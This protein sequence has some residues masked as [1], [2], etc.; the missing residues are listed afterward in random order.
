MPYELVGN[1]ETQAHERNNYDVCAPTMGAGPAVGLDT[2]AGEEFY[3]DQIGDDDVSDLA[4][5]ADLRE[6]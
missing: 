5:E 2:Q 4:E 1:N 6:Q 3:Q